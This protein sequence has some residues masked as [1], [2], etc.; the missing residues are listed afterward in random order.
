MLPTSNQ[1]LSIEELAVLRDANEIYRKKGFDYIDVMDALSAFKRFPD[2][3]RL[4]A[5][6]RKLIS[7][8]K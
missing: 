2:L 7:Q 8:G 1:V 6:A 5:I 3:A 4:D